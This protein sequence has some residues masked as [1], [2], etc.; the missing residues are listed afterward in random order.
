[1]YIFNW[2]AASAYWLYNTPDIFATCKIARWTNE[3][4][5]TQPATSHWSKPVDIPSNLISWS[6]H[7]AELIPW[8]SYCF[9]HEL[10]CQYQSQLA[11]F[12][13]AF[14][15]SCVLLLQHMSTLQLFGKVLSAWFFATSLASW[16]M[17]DA[18]ECVV[19]VF[20]GPIMTK[21]FFAL[22]FCWLSPFVKTQDAGLM[23]TMKACRVTPYSLSRRLM[24][25]F[26]W[27]ETF[28]RWKSSFVVLIST[29]T[30]R[31]NS[32]GNAVW[33]LEE[34]MWE[35]INHIYTV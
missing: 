14:P 23:L 24:I 22:W 20:K 19:V 29:L 21:Q 30:L 2:L 5:A 12:L 25:A 6:R 15:S 34:M 16:G 9:L 11:C 3:K 35:S 31:W 4:G 32:G 27:R 17:I 10:L 26:H 7:D 33:T 28:H 8:V 13:L 1:M 18:V